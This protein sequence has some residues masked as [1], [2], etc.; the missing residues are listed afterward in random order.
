MKILLVDD[1][2]RVTQG[3][4]RQ[5]QKYRG[6]WEIAGTFT[7]GHQALEFLA[8]QTADVMLTDIRMPEMDGLELV[9]QASALHPQLKAVILTGYAEFEYAQSA[10]KFGVV[11]YLLKPVEYQAVIELLDQLE[12]TITPEQWLGTIDKALLYI[13]EHYSDSTLSLT[14]VADYVELSAPHFSRLFKQEKRESF[15]QYLTRLRLQQAAFLLENSQLKVYEI[16]QAV[17][18][19]DQHYFYNL[20]KKHYNVTPL[21]FREE[22][23]GK[24]QP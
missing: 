11:R 24:R 20:F 10:I 12:K 7:T 16:G 8:H 5:L 2:E 19:N 3:L 6:H 4:S 9:R 18:Y 22:A 14:G 23:A 13:D 17:G 21:Q 1:E 15:I